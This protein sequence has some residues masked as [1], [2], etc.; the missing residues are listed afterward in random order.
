MGYLRFDVALY[1]PPG[2]TPAMEFYDT[3]V[4]HE[5]RTSRI[6]QLVAPIAQHFSCVRNFSVIHEKSEHDSLCSD[7]AKHLIYPYGYSIQYNPGSE[8]YYD[9]F[10]AL[11]GYSSG[12]FS[13]G[14]LPYIVKPGGICLEDCICSSLSAALAPDSLPFLSG[15]QITYITLTLRDYGHSPGRN[16]SQFDIDQAC[17]FARFLDAVF[18]VVPDDLDKLTDYEIPGSAVIARNARLSMAHR[19]FLYSGSLVNLFVAS[20]PACL[21]LFLQDAKTILFDFGAGGYMDNF[22]YYRRVGLQPL[23]QSFIDLNGYILWSKEK[24]A[25]S[26]RSLLDAYCALS[27]SQ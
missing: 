20:G 7:W 12:R 24:G 2:P 13:G 18:V 23:R 22:Q 21:S 17:E 4:S 26:S 8:S 6:F 3:Y 5:Q 14:T 10:S 11:R 19:A 25:Y 1:C 15:N 9:V 16:T 27:R